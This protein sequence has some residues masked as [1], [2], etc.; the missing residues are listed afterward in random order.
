MSKIFWSLRI[1]CFHRW[2]ILYREAKGSQVIR[3]QL[4]NGISIYNELNT[5]CFIGFN[6]KCLHQS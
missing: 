4:R 3:G 2:F 1:H 6:F 5:V